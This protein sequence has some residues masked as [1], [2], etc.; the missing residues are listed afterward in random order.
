MDNTLNKNTRP[1]ARF[2][3]RSVPVH[4]FHLTIFRSIPEICSRGTGRPR[5][6]KHRPTGVRGVRGGP[7]VVAASR[8]TRPVTS[9]PRVF[10]DH[11]GGGYPWG[12]SR[13]FGK[14]AISVEGPQKNGSLGPR[15]FAGR[16]SSVVARGHPLFF[17]IFF[18]PL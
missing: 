12:C 4:R 8:R 17:L 10:G 11:E 16:C 3:R 6:G 5:P 15:N 14:C 1:E 18:H 7:N 13:N 2:S 9:D